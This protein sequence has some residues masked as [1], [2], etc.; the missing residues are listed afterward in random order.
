MRARLP[1]YSAFR[2]A[3]FGPDD[4]RL[5]REVLD[6]LFLVTTDFDVPDWVRLSGRLSEDQAAAVTAIDAAI[7]GQV[8]SSLPGFFAMLAF[9]L[10]S[11]HVVVAVNPDV[12]GSAT[13][14]TIAGNVATVLSNADGVASATKLS[15]EEYFAYIIE[16]RKVGDLATSDGDMGGGLVEDRRDGSG[17]GSSSSSSGI[18]AWAWAF[19]GLGLLAIV[20]TATRKR[21]S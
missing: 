20:L 3:P 7:A 19:G 11:R 13:A 12:E 10:D 16:G 15:G 2:G 6:S 4:P 5:G 17:A 14:A 8:R 9:W 21:A 18:P 1:H